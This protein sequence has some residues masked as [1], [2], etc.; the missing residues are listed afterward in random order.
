MT[1][2]ELIAAM[3]SGAGFVQAGIGDDWMQGRSA[4]GGLQAAI[5]LTAMRTLAPPEIP[6]RTLQMTFIAPVPAGTVGASARVLR[7][8]RSTTQVEAR[9]EAGGELLAHAIGVFGTARES[10]V[11]RG[12]P[13][14]PRKTAPGRVL[15][16]VA[17]IAPAFMQQFRIEL[18]D[19][20]LPFAG[21]HISRIAYEL[22]LRDSGA[23]TEAHLLAIADFVPPVAL[24]WLPKPSPGSSVTWM[25]ELLGIDFAA[26]PLDGWRVESEMVAARDG[27]TNQSSTIWAPDGSAVALSRQSM[28]VFA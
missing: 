23:M 24:S 7:A 13:P 17:G 22:G 18:V 25:L 12:V 26:Q 10:I 19:G 6:L 14:P 28:V 1:L 15:P 11:R 3:R 16:Y 4:F 2:S 9:L 21:Q 8:G 5:A 20:A 27:Y